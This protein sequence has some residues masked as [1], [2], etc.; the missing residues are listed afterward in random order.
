MTVVVIVNSID[1]KANFE[2][3]QGD[4]SSAHVHAHTYINFHKNRNF[5]SLRN[6]ITFGFTL[7]TQDKLRVKGRDWHHYFTVAQ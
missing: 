3:R 7:D 6:Q 4:E 5:T 2:V 1:V